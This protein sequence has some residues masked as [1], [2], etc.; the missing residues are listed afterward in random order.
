MKQRQNS[1][2]EISQT[3]EVSVVSADSTSTLSQR[4]RKGEPSSQGPLS[5]ALVKCKFCLKTHARRKEQCF[6]WKKKCHSCGLENHFS[7]SSVCKGKHFNQ[8]QKKKS[9]NV[10]ESG[11]ESN[12]SDSDY[13]YSTWLSL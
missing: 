7:G 8:K 6:A 4:S 10:L 2:K 5:A 9:V 12:D 1:L 11:S 13:T 3:E